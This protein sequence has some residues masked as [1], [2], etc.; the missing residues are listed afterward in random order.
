M[1]ISLFK[2]REV[3][4]IQ[5]IFSFLIIE[6]TVRVRV[7]RVRVVRVNLFPALPSPLWRHTFRAGRGIPMIAK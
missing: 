3:K 1:L 7:V 2:I 5:I 6:L 4:Q